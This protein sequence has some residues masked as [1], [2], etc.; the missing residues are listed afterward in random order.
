VEGRWRGRGLRATVERCG[1]IVQGGSTITQQL[2]KN[3]FLAPD[4]TVTRKVQEALLALWLERK[5]SK[6]QL[7]EIYLNRVY[8]G[9]GTYGVD[10]AAHRSFDKYA[11]EVTL[12][13]KKSLASVGGD[14][15][16]LS[17]PVLLDD[18]R[19][20]VPLL[21]GDC[22][23]PPTDEAGFLAFA[24]SLRSPALCDLVQRVGAYVRF[25]SSIPAPLN[26]L[27]IC[28]AGRKWGA[29]YEF[30]A[31]RRLGID[32]E[33]ALRGANEKFYRR[34]TFMERRAEMSGRSLS[35]L[36]LDE[37]EQLWQL[38]KLQAA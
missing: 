2:A 5:F 24:Y 13:D 32:A 33:G 3:L 8:L 7:L 22:D 11:R 18:G 37:L 16:L 20:L 26:E 19:W 17:S 27:A 15:R 10:A 12:Y 38:A 30:Y 36:T 34:F 25:G 4:R 29:Q 28:M 9:A 35:E 6:D 23:Y 31:H 1:H 14:L 21:G